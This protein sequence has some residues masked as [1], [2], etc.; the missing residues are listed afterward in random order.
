MK[1]E[2][3][4]VL[5]FAAAFFLISV[6]CFL[7]PAE[8]VS[9]SERRKLA[10]FPELSAKSIANG[11]FMNGFEKYAADQFPLRDEL[12]AVKAWTA[13][14]ILRQKDDHG[15][16]VEDGIA[17]KMEYPLDEKSVRHACDRFRTIYD[18]YL[19]DSGC[20]SYLTVVPDKNY[21]L[22]E[23]SGH[24]KMD[25]ERLLELMYTENEFAEPVEIVGM[26]EADD[27]YAADIHW[28]QEK[29]VDVADK[30]AAEMGT[31][32]SGKYDKKTLEEPFY[33]VYFGQSALPLDGEAIHYLTNE[34]L[35]ACRVTNFETGEKGGIY[36]LE[37]AEGNDAYDLFLSGPVSL[38]TIENPLAENDRELIIFRDSFGSSLAP[39]LT[40]GYAKITLVDI[41]YLPGAHLEKY[42]EFHGQDVLFLYST[43]VLNNSETMK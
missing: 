21:F 11:N 32:I 35:E 27:Y 5:V 36:D 22:A 7:K 9:L 19:K 42:I 16:Y 37:K 15:I 28:R 10:Q 25:Y 23:Q 39:L 30:I 29:I 43:T 17:V 3:I 8:E 33:G 6:C 24:L 2:K 12:R 41:R 40:E 18:T 20:K 4:Q 13:K 34:T 14:N 26:L 1:H 38:L 31:E